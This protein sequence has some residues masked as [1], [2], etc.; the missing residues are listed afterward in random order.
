MAV[1]T[2]PDI[3][4]DGDQ[5]NQGYFN[6]LPK[7]MNQD[8]TGGTM[9]G[10]TPVAETLIGQVTITANKV[11]NGILVI[12]TGKARNADDTNANTI[13]L[14]TGTN[15]DGITS[16]THQKTITREVYTTTD[17]EMIDVGWAMVYY[18]TGLTWSST[19]YVSVTGAT[20]EGG[21]YITCES[22]VVLYF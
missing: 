12:A 19:Q 1:K 14:N 3:V 5:L 2:S 16:A 18:I 7:Y 22:I 20:A 21:R 4:V 15:A 9:G 8:Q 6:G 17:G 13:Y 11:T 10:G